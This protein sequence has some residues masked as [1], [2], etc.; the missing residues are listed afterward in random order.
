LD[1]GIVEGHIQ[2]AEGDDD[3]FHHRFDFIEVGDLADRSV[4]SP[5]AAVFSRRHS[6]QL[7]SFPC[8]NAWAGWA[9]KFALP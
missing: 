1:A 2:V 3:P 8:P 7:S 6:T 5:A 9:P 4:G